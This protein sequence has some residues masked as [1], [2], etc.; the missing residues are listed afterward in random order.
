M[1]RDNRF[2]PLAI[3]I[4][5]G[6]VLQILFIF[7]DRRDTPTK[8]I[9]EFTEA[10]FNVDRSMI[11]RLCDQSKT[12]N[13][14]DVVDRYIETKSKDAADRGF[15]MF[16]MK[17]RVSDLRTRLISRDD[18]SATLRLTAKVKPPLKA[19]FTGEGYRS[20]DEV[21]TVINEDGK[22]KVCGNI[23]SLAER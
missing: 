19:F 14:V 23:F 7:P 15:G 4:I 6:V 12:V 17:D 13:D 9:T 2:T 11:D 18:S 10:Y 21:V 3:P 8:A 1:P 16:Y 20:I 5:I 22:W